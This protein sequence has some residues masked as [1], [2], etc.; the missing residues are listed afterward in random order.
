MDENKKTK[1]GFWDFCSEHPFVTFIL[2]EEFIRAIVCIVVGA[3]SRGKETT[4]TFQDKE[5][6]TDDSR[7]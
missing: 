1:R 2:G 4:I 6:D 3:M 7:E 5:D